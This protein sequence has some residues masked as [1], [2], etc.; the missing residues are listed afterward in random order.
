MDGGSPSEV[1]GCAPLEDMRGAY[2]YLGE[3]V[4]EG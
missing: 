1:V 3:G 2:K 4:V